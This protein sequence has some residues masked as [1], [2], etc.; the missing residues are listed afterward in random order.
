M[1]NYKF[2][3]GD[4]IGFSGAHWHSDTINLLTYGVPRWSL[5]HVGIISDTR[6]LVLGKKVLHEAIS[7]AG[8]IA[9]QASG[10]VNTYN[11]RVWVYPLHRSLY[12]HE[13]RRL[14]QVLDSA[15]DIPYDMAGAVRAGG[16]LFALIESLIWRQD[17]SSY[18]CS[19]LVASKLSDIGI[20]PT[21]NAN[22]WNPNSLVRRLRREGIIQKPMRLK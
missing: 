9:R 11:G 4:I 8:V 16:L 5:S 12:S 15:I 6:N 14:R 18:F 19:E 17:F 13:S 21:T 7:T 20:F 2:K 3:S 1:G 10:V 22:R